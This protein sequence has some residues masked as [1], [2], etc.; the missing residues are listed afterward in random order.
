[1]FDWTL[2]E[3]LEMAK[4]E[5]DGTK[6]G[7]EGIVI[8]PAEETYSEVLRGRMSFKCLNTDYLLREE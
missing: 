6:Y 4:G 7:R 8:R 3:L 2:E 5:Y 1:V